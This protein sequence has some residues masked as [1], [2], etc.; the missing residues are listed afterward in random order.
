MANKK[1]QYPAL[2]IDDRLEVAHTHSNKSALDKITDTDAEN[3]KD[4]GNKADITL[5]NVEN[6]DFKSKAEEAGVAFEDVAD[7]DRIYGRQNGAWVDITSRAVNPEITSNTLDVETTDNIT[8]IE[9]PSTTVDAIESIDDKVDKVNITIGNIL[10]S[11]G[12]GNLQDSGIAAIDVVKKSELADDVTTDDPDIVPS[13]ALTHELYELINGVSGGIGQ[14]RGSVYHAFNNSG[15]ADVYTISTVS[16][17]T[18]NEGTGYIEGSLLGYSGVID[19]SFII[20]EVDDG[21]GGNNKV[22]SV[23]LENGGMFESNIPSNIIPYGGGESATGLHLNVTTVT[24]A[25]TTLNDIDNPVKGDTAYVMQDE[26]HNDSRSIWMYTELES[27]AFG[28]TWLTS[29]APE[30]RNFTTN[31]IQTNEIQDE[32]VTSEKLEPIPSNTV[33]A[34]VSTSEASPQPVSTDELFSKL[35]VV[36]GVKGQA[37][38][39]YR[40]GEVVL[41]PQDIGWSKDNILVNSA[42]LKTSTSGSD[43]TIDLSDEV[44]AQLGEGELAVNE[45]YFINEAY[46]SST[47]LSLAE[48]GIKIIADSG[49][50]TDSSTGTKYPSS[51]TPPASS[52]DVRIATTEFTQLAITNAILPISAQISAIN[53]KLDLESGTE[54][55]ATLPYLTAGTYNIQLYAGTWTF[56]CW[57]AQ[58]GGQYGGLGGY[59]KTTV[60]VTDKVTIY[61]VVGSQPGNSNGGFNGGGSSA[62]YSGLGG[63]CIG[64]GGGGATHVAL[65]DGTLSNIEDQ[66]DKVLVVAGG[67]GGSYV[68][69]ATSG[70]VMADDDAPY[71]I[72]TNNEGYGYGGGL[73]GGIG[74]QYSGAHAGE[75]GTQTAGGDRGLPYS[76]SYDPSDPADQQRIETAESMYN[77][78]SGTFGKG[79][80]GNTTSAPGY[81]PN[82]GGAGGGGWY[83]GGGA[84]PYYTSHNGYHTNT[85]YAAGGGGSGYINVFSNSQDL[86]PA[87]ENIFVKLNDNKT[88][89]TALYNS[90]GEI[91]ITD[92]NKRCVILN[93]NQSYGSYL[94]MPNA[95]KNAEERWV[96][97]HSGNGMAKITYISRDTN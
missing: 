84:T 67:G 80:N 46:Q 73:E 65:V 54:D 18:A 14:T 93:G 33:L 39:D 29:F 79:G 47:R 20:N 66:K 50:F 11:A 32:A 27:G 17:D 28:W 4:I 76:P 75:G 77:P 96:R 59:A 13:T 41:S 35:D 12:S 97:G 30:S 94:G 56:E 53:S 2:E 23:S 51:L 19:A 57:G 68:G 91:S 78:T 38:A 61:V 52:N 1:L 74:Y 71:S 3:I 72:H 26:L 70:N 10:S 88:L 60:V 49:I 31:P 8:T 7:N 6:S 62:S 34:N 36:T 86:E 95:D 48:T 82:H 42:H 83:G 44:V 55:G 81:S 45:Q 63:N 5:D 90:S 21:A 87:G 24:T 15:T 89:T 58:G 92:A 64:Y 85:C 69:T 40:S 9:L 22:I 37:E 43:I 25:R 16:V